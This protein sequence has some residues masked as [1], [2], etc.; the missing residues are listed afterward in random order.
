MTPGSIEVQTRGQSALGLF[1]RSVACTPRWVDI[2]M[3][4]RNCAGAL[5]GLKNLWRLTSGS[6]SKLAEDYQPEER[7][8]IFTDFENA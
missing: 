3:N 6:N 4:L 1:I 2:C 5:V 8:D 7:V